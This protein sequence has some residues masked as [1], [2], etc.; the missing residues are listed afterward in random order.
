MFTLG[1]S[2]LQGYH[3]VAQ[4]VTP[5]FR[6]D[7]KTG[8]TDFPVRVQWL[9]LHPSVAEGTGSI[10]GQ[11]TKIPQVMWP[12][13]III[14]KDRLPPQQLSLIDF[15]YLLFPYDFIEGTSLCF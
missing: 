12:K 8:F 5:E 6:T 10:P 2:G 4:V 7:D 3:R 11:E 9:R 13:I 14:I 15:A 1:S